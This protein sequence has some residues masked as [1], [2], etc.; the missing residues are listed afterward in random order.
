MSPKPG[1]QPNRKLE[2]LPDTEADLTSEQAE[3]ARGGAETLPFDTRPRAPEPSDYLLE[4]D[5]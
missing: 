4:A 1:E 2:D 5:G 3:A